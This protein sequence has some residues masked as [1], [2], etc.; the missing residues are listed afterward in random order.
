VGCRGPGSTF[1]KYYAEY[2]ATWRFNV[3]GTTRA[4]IFS[5]G[6][7]EQ[8]FGLAHSSLGHQFLGYLAAGVD[9]IWKGYDHILFLLSLFAAG[10][11]GAWREEVGAE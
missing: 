7:A 3:G 9:H 5:P 11:G 1:K 10:S 6:T 2:C 8:T 4:A